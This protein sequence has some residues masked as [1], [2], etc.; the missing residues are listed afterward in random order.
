MDSKGGEMNWKNS[1]R[2][3]DKFICKIT[4]ILGY[5][6]ISEPPVEE[7]RDRNTDLIVLEL[8]AIR[9]GCRIRKNSYYNRYPNE[10]TIRASVPS[11]NETEIGKIMNGWGHYFFY[12]F[13]NEDETD[14]ADWFIGDLNVLRRWLSEQKKQGRT[15]KEDWNFKSNGCGDSDFLVLNKDELPSNF[16]FASKSGTKL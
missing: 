11:G 16:I 12:G 8:N 15:K 2:W 5:H 13:A 10:F 6:F 3:S 9:F 1:K 4:P 7:D 14:L